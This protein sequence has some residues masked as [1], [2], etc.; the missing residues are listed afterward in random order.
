MLASRFTNPIDSLQKE[1]NSFIHKFNSF[2][3][4]QNEMISRNDQDYQQKIAFI[5]GIYEDNQI[6]NLKCH[7]KKAK[8]NQR[9]LI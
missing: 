8:L 9:Y 4:K 6:N 3:Q 1:T 7:N 2:I 5:K